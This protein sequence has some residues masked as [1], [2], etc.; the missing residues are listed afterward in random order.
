M[1]EVP[2]GVFSTWAQTLK[3]GDA[4]EAAKPEGRFCL[5]GEKRALLIAAGSGITPMVALAQSALAN[6]A[7]VTL[8]FGNRTSNSIMF[9]RD[10]EALKDRYLGRFRLVHVLS[11]EAQDVPALNGRLDIEKLVNSV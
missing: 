11:R 9:R 3:P 2:G 5:G 1:R 8:L 10:I 6:G 4:L 7:E